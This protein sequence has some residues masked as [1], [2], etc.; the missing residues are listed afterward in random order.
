MSDQPTYEKNLINEWDEQH[1][2][3]KFPNVGDLDNFAKFVADYHNSHI[4]DQTAQTPNVNKIFTKTDTVSNPKAEAECCTNDKNPSNV[5]ED[6][7][8]RY[9]K[10]DKDYVIK[11]FNNWIDKHPGISIAT[12]ASLG[13]LIS[14]KLFQAFYAGAI[15]KGNVRTIKYLKK[16]YK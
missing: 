8:H 1:P 12:I 7:T 16:Y 10:V 5:Y 13:L 3:H 15:Y 2:N 11:A 14:F 4:L 9:T 6:A